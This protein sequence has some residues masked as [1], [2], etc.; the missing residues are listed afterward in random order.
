MIKTVIFM[1]LL[2]VIVVSLLLMLMQTGKIWYKKRKSEEY[3]DISR[4]RIKVVRLFMIVTLMS[5]GIVLIS[6]V[7][8]DT[9]D[10]E[11]ESDSS[12]SE[13]IEVEVNGRKEWISIRGNDLDNPIILFLAGGPGGT[14][15]GAVRRNLGD[16]EKDYIVVNWEQP[17]SGKSY[18]A[19]SLDKISPETY[20]DD[21]TAI[22]N[23]LIERFKKEK[24]YLMGES[25][26]SALGIFLLEKAPENYYAFIGTGQMVDFNETEKECYNLA[27][28]I[29]KEKNDVD[30][31]EELKKLGAP[32]YY[33]KNMALKAAKY[34]QYLSNEMAHNPDI[35]N[36]GYDTFTDLSSSEYGII[37]QINFFR[38]VLTTF[39]FVYPQLYEVDL[40]ENYGEL[41]VPVY[42]LIGRHDINAPTYLVE[43]YF[44][45]LQAPDKKLIWFENSGHSPWIN[46]N[47]LFCE[48][49]AELFVQHISE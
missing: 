13:L 29:A 25:W 20:I 1:I 14:Q 47:G 42:F 32:P 30:K 27:L 8:A 44:K 11:I 38:G 26:G 4:K 12:I 35:H 2:V 45:Q 41:D 18:N 6:Q 37:D 48:T 33:G 5:G 36:A 49:T 21:G 15:L 22:T 34:L 46:E 40:R 19:L 16:L 23:Y 9:P 31:T 17:G 28:E 3:E 43:D 39:S 24:I 7:S 10:I